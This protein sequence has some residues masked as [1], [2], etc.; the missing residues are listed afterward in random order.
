MELHFQCLDTDQC[1]SS[2]TWIYCGVHRPVCRRFVDSIQWFNL[3]RLNKFK[4]DLSRVF[5]MKDLGEAQFVLGIQIIRDRKNRTLTIS[6][7]E[8]VKRIVGN[9]QLSDCKPT[10]T[11]LA[12]GSHL[13]KADCPSPDKANAALKLRYQ[14]AVGAIIN[15]M[16]GTRPDI[17]YAVT[18]LSQFSSNPGV[19]HWQALKHLGR[20]LKGT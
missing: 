2:G 1:V 11:P 18:R 7:C 10:C 12:H 8:Y 3:D 4:R 13:T 19:V 16:N 20:Y 9:L 15:A 6:Q 14:S 17:A 5:D